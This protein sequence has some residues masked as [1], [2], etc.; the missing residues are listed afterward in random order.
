CSIMDRVYSDLPYS[1]DNFLDDICLYMDIPRITVYTGSPFKL[2]RVSGK[3]SEDYELIM[4]NSEY[5]NNENYLDRFDKKGFFLLN[6]VD[7]FKVN[8]PDVYE[9]LKNMNIFSLVQFKTQDLS[10]DDLLISFES[11]GKSAP[12][13]PQ[14]I[15]YLNLLVKTTPLLDIKY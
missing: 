7:F 11:I 13:N 12:W 4:K 5:V 3:M 6:N 14:T 15:K 1:F 2:I 9:Q 10:G 8:A